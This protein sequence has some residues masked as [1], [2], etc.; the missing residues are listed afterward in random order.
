MPARAVPDKV[1]GYIAESNLN[2]KENIEAGQKQY[3]DFRQM[4]RQISAIE[5]PVVRE[6]LF[7]MVEEAA[8]KTDDMVARNLIELQIGIY[9]RANMFDKADELVAGNNAER[10]K[11]AKEAKAS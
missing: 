1:S 9:V 11:A 7:D 4:L 8:V 10:R 3:R 2:A 6:K 5:N